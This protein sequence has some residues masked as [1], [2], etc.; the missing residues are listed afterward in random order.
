MMKTMRMTR[1]ALRVIA[2]ATATKRMKTT[3]IRPAAVVTVAATETKRM[4][5]MTTMIVRDAAADRR[6]QTLMILVWDC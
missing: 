3:K 6:H 2:G 4:S 1:P 5:L